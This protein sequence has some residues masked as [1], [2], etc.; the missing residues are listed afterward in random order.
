MILVWICFLLSALLVW[1]CAW[2]IC[3]VDTVSPLSNIRSPVLCIGEPTGMNCVILLKWI[4]C[5]TTPPITIN[6]GRYLY[7]SLPILPFP[8][9][10]EKKYI[11]ETVCEGYSNLIAVC[12]CFCP[13]H[14]HLGVKIWTLRSNI[15]SYKFFLLTFFLSVVSMLILQARIILHW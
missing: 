3:L 5:I 11:G 7:W 1:P 15:W 12:S 10:E 2:L 13:Y 9:A 8:K 4:I 6:T 14:P